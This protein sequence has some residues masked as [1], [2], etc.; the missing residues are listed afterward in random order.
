MSTI[1]DNDLKELKDFINSKFD[2]VER[3][4]EQF[5]RKLETLSQDMNSM[6]IEIATVKEGL[7]SVKTRL[8][9]WKPLITKSAEI[10][11]KIGE[12]KNWKQISIILL[13]GLITSFLWYFR[14]STN[15]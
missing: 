10:S 11:E 1:T 4:N 9:D 15:F 14:N 2:Q 5:D 7:N 3:K 13:T 12:L 8:D 6:R